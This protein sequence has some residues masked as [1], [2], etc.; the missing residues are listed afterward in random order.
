MK[1]K[2]DPTQSEPLCISIPAA[3]TLLGVSRGTAYLMA[4]LGQL[5]T[6]RC[7][8]RRMVVP[9]AR[10]KQMLEKDENIKDR[11]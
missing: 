11:R 10:L 2:H 7:G 1:L 8:K 9:M 6:I 3:G 5:P 4:N